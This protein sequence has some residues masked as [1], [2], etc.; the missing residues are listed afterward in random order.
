MS[1]EQKQP[2]E[3]TIQK[4]PEQKEPEDSTLTSLYQEIKDLKQQIDA[5]KTPSTTNKD[6][7]LESI[8]KQQV[9]TQQRTKEEISRL[10][11]AKYWLDNNLNELMEY[12]K[13]SLSEPD[14]VYL[15]SF[16][17]VT[18]NNPDYDYAKKKDQI[19]AQLLKKLM[20]IDHKSLNDNTKKR[21][22]SGKIDE[23]LSDITLNVKTQQNIA[24]DSIDN[25]RIRTEK[26]I[27]YYRNRFKQI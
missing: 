13:P 26:L 2:I 22:M 5:L 9:K 7:D 3:D 14:N 11:E 23:A 6:S 16:I 12:F 4:E 1:I 27:K 20:E 25:A 15:K 17:D 10:A 21:I 24:E 19:V 8:L 18:L